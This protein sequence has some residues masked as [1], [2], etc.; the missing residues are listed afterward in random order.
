MPWMRLRNKGSPMHCAIAPTIWCPTCRG[1]P[2]MIKRSSTF[3]NWIK[4]IQD[5][6][7]RQTSWLHNLGSFSSQTE[8]HELCR[9]SVHS[10]A[11]LS[12]KDWKPYKLQDERKGCGVGGGAE[13][14]RTVWNMKLSSSSTVSSRGN[15]LARAMICIF[16]GPK[17]SLS[18]CDQYILTHIRKTETWLAFW[19][20]EASFWF[21]LTWWPKSTHRCMA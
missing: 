4:L 6:S 3:K 12:S 19:L 7:W 18:Y 15:K 5:W 2:F 10:Y 16:F 9:S 8:L 20:P 17:Q 21:A 13:E 11:D 14:Q 1:T